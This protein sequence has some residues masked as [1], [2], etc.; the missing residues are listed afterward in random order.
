MLTV[1]VQKEHTI[2]YFIQS[3][4]ENPILS[5]LIWSLAIES[6]SFSKEK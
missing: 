3:E 1:A 4:I 6:I 5:F 2:V